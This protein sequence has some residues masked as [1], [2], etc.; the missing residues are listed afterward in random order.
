MQSNERRSKRN[1][2]RKK[3]LLKSSWPWRNLRSPSSVTIWCTTFSSPMSNSLAHSLILMRNLRPPGRINSVNC[4]TQKFWRGT[5]SPTSSPKKN[6]RKYCQRLNSSTSMTSVMVHKSTRMRRT[7]TKREY[8]TTSS[9]RSIKKGR[10]SVHIRM[11][12]QQLMMLDSMHIWPD[13][14]LLK[15]QSSLK[16]EFSLRTQK[17]QKK[18]GKKKDG[19][20]RWNRKSR[21]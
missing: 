6:G 13:L 9:S 4:M 19:K 21:S 20:Q 17:K 14:H 10:N 1:S 11:V 16:L 5:S 7:I 18:Q 3:A 15:W 12:E 2:R 8:V